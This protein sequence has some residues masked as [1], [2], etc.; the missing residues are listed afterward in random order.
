MDE[1]GAP[2][3][4]YTNIHKYIIQKMGYSYS[5]GHKRNDEQTQTQRTVYVHALELEVHNYVIYD[6]KRRM[7]RVCDVL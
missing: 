4:H 3:S 1:A 5:I 7:T 2:A 6:N